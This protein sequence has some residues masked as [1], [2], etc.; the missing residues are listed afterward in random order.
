MGTG[1]IEW[2]QR[3]IPPVSLEKLRDFV[4]V[5]NTTEVSGNIFIH[6]DPFSTYYSRGIPDSPAHF[7]LSSQVQAS[8]GGPVSCARD[9][10]EVAPASAGPGTPEASTSPRCCSCLS[11]GCSGRARVESGVL[12]E[13]LRQMD[14]G[15]RAPSGT[16]QGSVREKSR[17]MVLSR[18]RVC[19]V[20]DGLSSSG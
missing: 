19:R 6:M 4:C 1:S 8:S 13:V 7:E 17:V 16:V 3:N 2:T 10:V 12:P 18:P 9:R 20:A 11:G 5:L 15:P 14:R